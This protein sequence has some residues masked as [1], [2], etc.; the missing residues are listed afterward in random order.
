MEACFGVSTSNVALP[1]VARDL[2]RDVIFAEH[3]S[4]DRLVERDREQGRAGLSLL[5]LFIIAMFIMSEKQL[6]I[7]LAERCSISAPETA[8]A[9]FDS[10]A[11]LLDTALTCND[12]S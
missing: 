12:Q 7:A 5:S 6:C 11:P 2:L 9:T 3:A 10:S 8:P 1:L 4:V